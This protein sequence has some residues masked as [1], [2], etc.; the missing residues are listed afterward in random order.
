M[1]KRKPKLGSGKRFASLTKSLRARGVK[2]P[3]ALA[4]AIGRKKFGAKKMSAMAAA[5][6]RRA[7]KRRMR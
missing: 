3:K 1:T 7:A 2:N 6:R 4:A 5:G